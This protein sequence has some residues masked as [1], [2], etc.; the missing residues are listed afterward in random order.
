MV[1]LV[2]VN[3]TIAT[4]SSGNDGTVLLVVVV[5]ANTSKCVSVCGKNALCTVV[6]MPFEGQSI[7][8]GA[9]CDDHLRSPFAQH[10]E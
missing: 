10:A 2:V 4:I 6:L 3:P 8:K 1:M 9:L 5:V 7:C